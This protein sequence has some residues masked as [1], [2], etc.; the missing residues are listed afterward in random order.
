MLASGPKTFKDLLVTTTPAKY[1]MSLGQVII[2]LSILG[3]GY[4]LAG[5]HAVLIESAPKDKE[6]LVTSPKTAVLRFNEKIE[7]SMARFKLTTS[8]GRIISLPAPT[9]KDNSQGPDCLTV[10]LPVLKRGDYL[11]HYKILSIDGHV[12]TG[13]IRFSVTGSGK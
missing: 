3:A 2:I 9:G 1:I 7:K 12:V 6:M 4:G 10:L 13:V 11:L 8:E 5:A